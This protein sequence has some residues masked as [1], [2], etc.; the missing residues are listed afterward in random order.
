MEVDSAALLKAAAETAQH[1]YAPYSRF[2]VGAAVQVASGQVYTGCNV[3]NASYGLTMCAE[4]VAVFNAISEGETEIVAVAVASGG[5]A[6][7][8]GACRQVLH[9]F[10]PE[11][12]V[13]LGDRV[14]LFSEQT[15]LKDLLP[16][17]FGPDFKKA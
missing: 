15:S 10:G 8:C 9:E 1:A 12:T 17:P 2:C 7:P 14:G 4:R 13:I 3:E 5:A 6:Y 11:M 16:K